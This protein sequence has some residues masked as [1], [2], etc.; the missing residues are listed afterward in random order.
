M[1]SIMW[2][3]EFELAKDLCVELIGVNSRPSSMM[4]SHS[5]AGTCRYRRDG[6]KPMIDKTSASVEQ[7]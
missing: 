1:S 6:Q 3:F 4:Q 5:S 7:V 2:K